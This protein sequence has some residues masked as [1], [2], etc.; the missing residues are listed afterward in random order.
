MMDMLDKNNLYEVLE[1][2][3][4]LPLKID[5]L[6]I[7]KFLSVYSL[8]EAKE[9]KNI[10]YFFMSTLPIPRLN[11]ESRILYIGK[12]K[13]SFASRYIPQ[14]KK[15][16]TSVANILKYQAVLD[17]Y[18]SI[19]IRYCAFENFGSSIDQ[20][21]GQFLWWYFQNHGEYPP[22]NYTQTKVRRSEVKLPL[23]C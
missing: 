15:Q 6:N 17:N 5:E 9:A 3:Q 11:G 7:H 21:E 14:A 12:T 19:E 16:A 18:G 23:N 20:A 4:K 22:F 8:P 13:N 1:R 10:I 2:F